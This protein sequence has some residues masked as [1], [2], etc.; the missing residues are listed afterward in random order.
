MVIHEI[1]DIDMYLHCDCGLWCFE[2]V[3][4]LAERGLG[5]VACWCVGVGVG[6]A[7]VVTTT[8]IQR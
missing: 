8:T 1:L 2:A 3:I 5:D 4:S 7:V 6:V